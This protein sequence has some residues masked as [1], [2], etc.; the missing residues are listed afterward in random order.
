MNK[1]KSGLLLALSSLPGDY[2]IGG[3]GKE[4]FKFIDFLEASR[5]SYWQI[6]PLGPTGY[7]N[8]P[9]SSLASLAG[10]PLY[11]DLEE[12][13]KV[14]LL[15]DEDLEHAK[16]PYGAVNYEGVTSLKMSLLRKAFSRLSQENKDQIESFFRANSWLD[17]FALF[18]TIKDLYQG[19]SWLD[20][21]EGYKNREEVS[22]KSIRNSHKKDYDFWI[23]TQYYFDKQR[24]ALLSYAKK[25]GISIIG[26]IPFYV[27]EDSVEVWTSPE[28]F[29]LGEKGY[30]AGTPP[31][32]FSKEGQLWGNPIYNYQLMKED[33][34]AWWVK[35]L[36][37]QSAL[38]HLL[39]LDHF[40]GF[41][42]Y[43]KISRGKS[44][45]EG[46]LEPGYGREILSQLEEELTRDAFIAED[47]GSETQAG[48]K[49]RR[50]YSVPGMRIL[51]F[52]FSP[53]K[54]NP[55]L[56]HSYEKDLFVY[57][58]THDNQPIMAWFLEAPKG[59]KDDVRA[60]LGKD[61][62]QGLDFIRLLMMSSADSVI[63]PLQDLLGLGKKA[64]MNLPGSLEN[65]WTWRLDSLESI[66]KYQPILYN[67][68]KTYR[69][70]L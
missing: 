2:G 48:K 57:T 6:L 42:S 28:L 46:K 33:N 40:N 25:K 11:L 34:F 44:P 8:S 17:D 18:M 47:L 54:D 24:R 67:F 39:R 43:W 31:D 69:R 9:Y 55:H 12:L 49:L 36:K 19:L 35:R 61:E 59:V 50:A 32:F 14:N 20:W 65:N 70:N 29:L 26:D 3:F 38:Y 51:Q 1:R 23:F 60:Y 30:V 16:L 45:G 56:P 58:G 53:G 27:A 21:P 37:D 5:Q 68:S 66:E 22:L 63:I 52:G 64:R 7:G 13:H 62:P 15:R 4:A 41:A 10:N